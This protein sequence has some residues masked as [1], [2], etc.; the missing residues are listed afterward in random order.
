VKSK[1][2]A[3]MNPIELSKEALA[4]RILEAS[5]ETCMNEPGFRDAK[6]EKLLANTKT[7]LSQVQQELERRV[8]AVRG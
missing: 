1:T 8:V 2:P 4:L 6:S 3:E 7:S 5:L